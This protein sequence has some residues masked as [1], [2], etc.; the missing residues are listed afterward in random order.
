M[1]VIRYW[2]LVIW[3]R[4]W[5]GRRQ[6][7]EDRGQRAEVRGQEKTDVRC[8]VSEGQEQETEIHRLPQYDLPDLRGRRRFP[9]IKYLTQRRKDAKIKKQCNKR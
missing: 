7:P 2:L 8:Q 4:W 3:N 1:R 9:Q 5:K 6:K